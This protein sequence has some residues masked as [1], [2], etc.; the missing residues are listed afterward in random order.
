V[1]KAE[2][3]FPKYCSLKW[4]NNAEDKYGYQTHLNNMAKKT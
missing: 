1:R 3:Y 2:R 4:L